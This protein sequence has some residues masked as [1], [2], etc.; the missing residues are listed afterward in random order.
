M[1][2]A[3]GKSK[4]KTRLSWR[5]VPAAETQVFPVSRSSLLP[6]L[7]AEGNTKKSVSPRAGEPQERELSGDR[8]HTLRC[9]SSTPAGNVLLSNIGHLV[10]PKAPCPPQAGP[11]RPS[12]CCHLLRAAGQRGSGAGLQHSS[13]G[14]RGGREMMATES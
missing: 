4:S 6:V 12:R 2:T 14:T 1:P 3:L 13:S 9:C 10:L 8:A 5:L 11:A 7:M